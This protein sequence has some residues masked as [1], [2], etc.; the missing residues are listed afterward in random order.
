M[1][2]HVVEPASVEQIERTLGVTEED[3]AIVRSVLGEIFDGSDQDDVARSHKASHIPDRL[4][5][6]KSK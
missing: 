6:S 5:R 2:R 3:R 4:I 1:R